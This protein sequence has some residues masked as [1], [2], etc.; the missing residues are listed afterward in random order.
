MKQ[1][2]DI[3]GNP[4]FYLTLAFLFLVNFSIAGCY[5]IYTVILIQ[6]I[7][8]GV[9]YIKNRK[10]QDPAIPL[11]RFPKLPPYFKYFLLY[12]LF[13]LLSSIF[14]LNPAVS[15]KHD[16]EFFIYLL[17]PVFLLIVNS[18]K[19]LEYCL[20]AVLA[21]AT[22]SAIYGIGDV[23]RRGASLDYRLRGFLSHWMTYSG[24]LMLAFIFFFVYVFYVKGL[25]RIVILSVCLSAMIT[26]IAF[27]LTRN[28][29]VGIAV[30]LGIFIV[31]SRPKI[32]FIAIPVLVASVFFLPASVKNRIF[33]IADLNNATNQDRLY[34]M[35]IGWNIF[36]DYPFFGVGPNNIETVYNL[37][38]PSEAT[39]TNMHLH[40]N[41]LHA[42]AERGIFALLSLL[43]AFISIFYHV[44]RKIKNT[45]GID[46]AVALSV[47]FAFTGFVIAGLFEYNY[48]D[49][50]TRFL[51]Y[52][53]I[54][55]P[56]LR[57]EPETIPQAQPVNEKA[58]DE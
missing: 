1:L 37:Y 40:N 31:Y 29:W 39:L 28:V 9:L 30:A 16:K 20:Y 27:S 44:I 25:K 18:R 6:F 12:I 19:R 2:F 8:F 46:K 50:E 38:K 10:K 58:N 41:F 45:T 21:S 7:G 57:L 24:L 23:I 48:G 32:L 43:A 36:K 56:F 5:I 51:L 11:F 33:S 34:M 47:L 14:G 53:L 13:T 55:L 35:K 42:L 4:A 17:I 49:S 15:L 3:T 26:A 52:F 54:S 22:L